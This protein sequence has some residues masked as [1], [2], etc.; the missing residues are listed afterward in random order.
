[1]D[2]ERYGWDSTGF[3]CIIYTLFSKVGRCFEL[4]P[5]SIISIYP[6]LMTELPGETKKGATVCTPLIKAALA[7]CA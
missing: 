1:M 2:A 5:Q 3:K 6:A 7:V 4:L